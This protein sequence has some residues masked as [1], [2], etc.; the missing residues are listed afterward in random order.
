MSIDRASPKPVVNYFLINKDR[1]EEENATIIYELV[2]EGDQDYEVNVFTEFTRHN[3][4]SNYSDWSLPLWA[5]VITKRK[6]SSLAAMRAMA[7]AMTPY[8]LAFKEVD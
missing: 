4:L 3:C 1:E 6:L 2:S 5:H 8:Y 7:F